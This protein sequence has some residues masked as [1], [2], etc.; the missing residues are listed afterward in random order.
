M[1]H[2]SAELLYAIAFVFASAWLA[3]RAG[4]QRRVFAE[5]L[6]VAVVAALWLVGYVLATTWIEYRTGRLMGR[7]GRFL[8]ALGGALSSGACH[9]LVPGVLT[10]L[11]VLAGPGRFWPAV[12]VA[13]AA[14]AAAGA[15]AFVLLAGRRRRTQPIS[16][17]PG[18]QSLQDFAAGQGQLNVWCE[19][20]AP[21]A[22]P[23]GSP[24]G[25]V[26]PGLGRPGRIFL[27]KQTLERM[28]P[29]QRRAIFA[30]ELAHHVLGHSLQTASAQRLI[31]AGGAVVLAGVLWFR[32]GRI[33]WSSASAVLGLLVLL[34]HV[35]ELLWAPVLLAWSRRQER[36]AHRRALEMTGEPEAYA[37]AMRRLA[38]SDG[39]DLPA[40]AGWTASHPTLHEV[41][42]LTEDFR[43]NASTPCS[44]HTAETG[45]KPQ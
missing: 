31:A 33:G 15:V 1:V 2:L 17:D 37:S 29:A 21:Q 41:L 12:G 11:A 34:E 28:D 40:R 19:L 43:R 6:A 8:P 13:A 27:D 44:P 22:M 5:L 30:H 16:E 10:V 18:V 20:L 23:G 3:P 38:G 45:S 26:G 32:L 25:Y 24:A 42:E 9:L 36:R 14:L 39:D 35:W 7:G 4:A